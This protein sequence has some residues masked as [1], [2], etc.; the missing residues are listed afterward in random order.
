M[1]EIGTKCNV[2]EKLI[3]KLNDEKRSFKIYWEEG[4]YILEIL[5]WREILRGLVR[6]EKPEVTQSIFPQFLEV[7]LLIQCTHFQSYKVY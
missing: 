1:I 3:I 4:R 2:N 6:K 5:H 7:F